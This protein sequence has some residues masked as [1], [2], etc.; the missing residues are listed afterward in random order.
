MDAHRI[1]ALSAALAV[2]AVA[3]GLLVAVDGVDSID[4]GWW[5]ALGALALGL[6]LV[7]WSRSWRAT[8]A[9]GDDGHIGS[10]SADA[11]ADADTD[12]DTDAGATGERRIW[13][14]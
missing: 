8:D 6:G 10:R 12:A 14:L 3:G 2:I 11:D 4:R 13:R 9:D 1:D 5:L 7:P